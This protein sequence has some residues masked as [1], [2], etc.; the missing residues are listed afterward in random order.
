MIV[1]HVDVAGR[2]LPQRAD[3]KNHAMVFPTLLVDL[4]HG[5]AGGGAGQPGPE[6]ARRLLAAELMRNRNDERCGHAFSPDYVTACNRESSREKKREQPRPGNGTFWVSVRFFGTGQS[7]S[8][9]PGLEEFC[10]SIGTII[11]IILVI[12]LLGGFSGIGGGPFYGTGY[13]GGG[14]LGL[15]V[16]ILLILLLMGR[17]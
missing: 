13:Y 5:K 17:L 6:T 10:M 15:V 14:G 12:A 11:L 3:A 4:E 8:A 1:E 7:N 9:L 2:R 16:V